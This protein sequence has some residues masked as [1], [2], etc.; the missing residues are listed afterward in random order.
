MRLFTNVT[1]L[2]RNATHST[3]LNCDAFHN[4][5]ITDSF[6]WRL[7]HGSFY[8]VNTDGLPNV[9]SQYIKNDSCV[10]VHS[11]TLV[12]LSG[13]VINPPTL[14]EATK[15]W[16]E[17]C[18]RISSSLINM[19]EKCQNC[20]IQCGKDISLLYLLIESWG[21]V[22]LSE[23]SNK[24]SFTK[25]KLKTTPMLHLGLAATLHVAQDIL[26][27]LVK[28]DHSIVNECA[29]QTYLLDSITQ[30]LKKEEARKIFAQ[31]KE[32]KRQEILAEKFV[33][34]S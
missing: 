19:A 17:A 4:E 10:K 11:T 1:G 34:S 23:K 16:R 5:G 15:P 27:N 3:K 29:G 26:N 21:G 32:M 7:K 30:I 22:S 14:P 12:S 24:L 6:I 9:E 13:I 25:S 33:D 8:P 28:H 31:K 18:F 2:I 20:A